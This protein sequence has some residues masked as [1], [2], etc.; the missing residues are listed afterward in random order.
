MSVNVIYFAESADTSHGWQRRLAELGFQ[1]LRCRDEG[2]AVR[3]A[4][5]GDVAGVIVEAG[6][7]SSSPETLCAL[8]RRLRATP[9][10]ASAPIIALFA[11]MEGLEHVADLTEAGISGVHLRGLPERFLVEPLKASR[12]LME[13]E[14]FR[15]TGMDV[16]TLANETRRLIH[17]LSQ[18]LAA[19]QGRLQIMA[20]KMPEGDPMREPI[21]L[22]VKLVLEVS[23]RL[24]DLQELQRKYGGGD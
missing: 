11:G 21:E 7:Q 5:M 22:M 24:R 6:M 16:R 2:R 23:A 18:P 13:L 15:S 10:T 19:L 12:S 9:E 14:G 4:R 17:E 1:V 20:L 8:V 3:F